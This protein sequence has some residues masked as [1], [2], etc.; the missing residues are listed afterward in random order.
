[1]RLIFLRLINRCWFYFKWGLVL[2]GMAVVAA[3]VY[4][5]YR[6]DEEIRC[7]VRDRLAQ[8]YRALEVSVRS[9]TLLEGEGIQLRGLSILEPGAEGPRAELIYCEE[10]RLQCGTDLEELV[11]S[12]PEVRQI[13]LRRPTLRVTRRPDGSW[14]AA[15]LLPLPPLSQRPPLVLIED[16]TIE[17]FDPLKNPA[18]TLTLRDV[19]LRITAP[20]E[21]GPH[22]H[23]RKLQGTLTADHVQQVDVE[24]TLDV[25]RWA[26]T[27]G[28]SI[29]G[30]D[31][32][33]QLRDALPGSLGARL[34]AWGEPRGQGTLS[35]RVSHDPEDDPPY[36]FDLSGRL[37]QGRIDDPRLPNPLTD[38]RA[39]MRLSNEGFAIDE[40]VA[41]CGEATLRASVR[42]AGFQWGSSPMALEAE[43]RQLELHG[44]LLDF[45]PPP[46]QQ[47]LQK[48]WYTYCPSGEVD[49]DLRL[50]YD[51]KTWQPEVFVRCLNVSFTHQRFQYRLERAKG[52]LELNDDVLRVNLT[53][54]SGPRPVEIAAE[55]H[56]PAAAAAGWLEARGDRIPLDEKLLAALGS[57]SRKTEATARSLNPAGTF[58]FHL[59]M[60]R[61]APQ[62]PLHKDLAIELNGCSIRYENF[63]Y[64][65]SNIRGALVM[66]DDHWTCQGLQGSNDTGRVTFGGYLTSA[67]QGRE[68]YLR[69]QAT[70]V[71]LEE[72]LRDAF[73]RHPQIRRAWNN[74]RPQGSVDL[75]EVVVHR[76][77]GQTR[78]TV[79]VRARPKNQTVSICPVRF[80]YRMEKLDGVLIYRD[81]QVWWEGLRAEHGAVRI[82]ADGRF[83]LLADGS[84]RLRVEA[85]AVDRL[86]LDD[87]ELIQA[88]PERLKRAVLELKPC[89]R[90]H[91]MG[92][93]CF[94]GGRQPDD[95]VRSQWDLKL[96]Y[97]GDVESG[98]RLQN[99][100]GSITLA[101]QSDGRSLRCRGGLD[102]DSLSFHGYQFTEIRGPLWIDDRHVLFGSWVAHRQNAEATDA[103]PLEPQPVRA[104][105][106]GGTVQ[107]DHWIALEPR[108]SYGL[109][110][111]LSGADVSRCAREV[112]VG[113][114]TLR[115]KVFATIDLGGVGRSIHGMQG[116]GHIRLRDAD[117]YELPLMIALLKILSIRE[118]D[119][120]AFSKSDIDF[121][122]Q[123]NHLYFNR[124]NFNGDAISLLG[125]GEMDFQS[126]IRLTFHA[127]VG[128]GELNLPL[129]REVFSG[130]SEQI[131]QIQMEGTL[132]DPVT[133]RV[134]LPAVNQALQQLEHG[135]GRDARSQGLLPPLRQWLPGLVDRQATQR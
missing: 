115:G 105:F 50:A 100:Y 122:I 123:G 59:R 76:P 77:P 16:G 108:R 101:G 80:P 129:F 79:T 44:R 12:E 36:R 128:R 40:L 58:D 7:R 53:A 23:A 126:N 17:I 106:C 107:A 78:A 56:H 83:D 4:F 46:L 37:V 99:I 34:A 134:P 93:L 91:L 73:V 66:H 32:S 86:R 28:G 68:L 65:L 119:R 131:M 124:I 9:A 10:I 81:G 35:F 85:L 42:Q 47:S 71:P 57:L 92:N 70:D 13:T 29:E 62:G 130:A 113:R 64:P 88:L 75:D 116:H 8:H 133:R 33:P 90:L 97:Q 22:P 39:V 30:M 63:S 111:V 94:Q 82:S 121:T 52:R 25:G 114:Q 3:V 27:I 96:L 49:A 19:N 38:V 31:V 102:I 127:L 18:S 87:R 48:H 118:P 69:F 11:G 72:E 98:V 45:L 61:D 6:V 120:T 112:M 55:V 26:W 89:G 117:V 84:S 132:Q 135:L 24:G 74:L 109:H 95:P 20:D 14:S 67:E 110:A 60:H 51:G 43:I 5:N 2:G 54:H 21:P 1:M 15:K 104:R 125:R 41:R 103:Q